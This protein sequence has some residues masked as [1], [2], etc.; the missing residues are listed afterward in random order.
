MAVAKQSPLAGPKRIG[1]RL[2][3]AGLITRTQLDL[4]LERQQIARETRQRLGR[5]LI[6]LGFLSERDLL[7]L[8]SIHFGVPAAASI[9][10]PEERAVAALPPTVGSRYQALPFQIVH[11]VL[12][13]AI[14][15]APTRGM[16]ENLQRASAH[17][18]RL[19]VAPDLDLDA[20]VAKHYGHAHTALAGRLRELAVRLLHLAE[21]SR[22]VGFDGRLHDELERTRK[23]IDTLLALLAD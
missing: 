6:D 16:I 18:I 20:A 19:Y 10:E 11:G 1:D 23:E 13:I 8:L 22:V 9:A 17:P 2:L 3:E 14:A 7:Q 4:A 15:D 5:T 12:Q 21:E